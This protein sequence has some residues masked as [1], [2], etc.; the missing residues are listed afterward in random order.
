MPDVQTIT[1]RLGLTPTHVHRAGEKHS[2][3][4]R[5]YEHDMWVYDAPVHEAEP[6]H[7]HIDSLWRAI[8]P[9]KEYLVGLKQQCKV[10]VYLG[11]R[12][13]SATAGLE[14]PYQSLEIFTE[15]QVPFGLSII[16]A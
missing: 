1:H 5:P 14:L 9:H 8:R 13:N 16:V 6:L 12:S 11:Y 4:A 15:L 2:R 10:D 3:T 7:G